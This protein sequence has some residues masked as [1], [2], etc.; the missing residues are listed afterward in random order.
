MGA[1]RRLLAGRQPGTAL[2]LV[3][4]EAGIGKSRL[5]SDFRASCA[6]RGTATATSRA[7]QAEGGLPYGPIIDLLRSPAV[8]ATLTGL[9]PVWRREI[10]RLLPELTAEHPEPEHVDGPGDSHRSILFEALA[11]ALTGTGGSLLMV[12]DDLQWAGV[13]TLE[14]LHFLV[15]FAATDQLLVVGTARTE[16]VDPDHPLTALIAGLNGIGAAT[17]IPLARLPE[18]DAA[19][20][21]RWWVGTAV[22]EEA[23]RR[24]VEESEGNPLFVVELA[25][26]GLAAAGHP[27]GAPAPG[28]LPPKVQTVIQ[29]RLAQLSTRARD[30]AGVA[31]VVGRAFSID[32]ITRL[33]GE[34]G[35]L[36]LALDELWRRGIVRERGATGTTSATT[37]SARSPISTSARRGDGSSTSRSRM[38]SRSCMTR[39]S[40]PW[41]GRSPST[42]TGPARSTVPL[43]TTSWP[44]MARPTSSPTRR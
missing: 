21:A 25:R 20:L 22:G 28:G 24:V 5:V 26:S 44:S 4:G 32:V 11:R 6:R 15:R 18:I 3:T 33:S 17:Q 8:R 29:R 10:A 39:R 43:A 27:G 31:A 16:E 2:A 12:I 38:P 35:D 13:E 30:V 41:P 36:V 14:F 42:S 1:A 23:V 7:Y 40:T 19:A 9:E 37:R 34:D